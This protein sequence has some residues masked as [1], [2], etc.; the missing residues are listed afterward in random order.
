MKKTAEEIAQI[1]GGVILG[2]G[3]KTRVMID[4]LV[5][6]NYS[7][8]G[9]LPSEH[10]ADFEKANGPFAKV[11]LVLVSHQHHDHNHLVRCKI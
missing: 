8:Y 4:G 10:V 7:V 2:D 5:V 6:E 11:N 9:G 1:V 3:N